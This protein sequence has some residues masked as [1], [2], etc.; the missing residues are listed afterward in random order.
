VKPLPRTDLGTIDIAAAVRAD[1]LMKDLLSVRFDFPI[2][3]GLS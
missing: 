3:F 1:F 2:V